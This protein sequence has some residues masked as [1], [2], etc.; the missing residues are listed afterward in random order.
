MKKA[1][2]IVEAISTGVFYEQDILDRGYQPLVIYPYIE[3]SQEDKAVYEG[4]REAS[5]KQLSDRTVEIPDDGDFDHLLTALA[6][7]DIACVVAGSE[8][9]S[10]LAD[11]L[12]EA[13]GLPGNPSASSILHRNKDLMQEALRKH[14]LRSIRG[15]VV[16]T[17]EEALQAAEEEFSNTD[18]FGQ[19]EGGLIM[20]ERIE[21]TEYIVNTVSRDGVHRVIRRWWSMPIRCWT[22]WI[23]ATAPATENTC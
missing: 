17:L 18:Y 3:S 9:G 1:V 12:A 23:S 13:L 21:G 11:R 19:R 10:V 16:H 7:Y 2:V 8:M 6:P 20:Q 15:K 5:R 22:P 4:I 14:G